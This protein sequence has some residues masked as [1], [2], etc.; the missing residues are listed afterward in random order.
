MLKRN[1]HN[2]QSD[3]VFLDDDATAGRTR[4]Y[5]RSGQL[6]RI[7]KTSGIQRTRTSNEPEHD[8]NYDDHRNNTYGHFHIIPGKET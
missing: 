1:C 8:N 4:L 2:V 5:H 3:L 6:V 7:T